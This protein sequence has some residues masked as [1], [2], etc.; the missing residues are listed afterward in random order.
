MGSYFRGVLIFPRSLRSLVQSVILGLFLDNPLAL[1]F[2]GVHKEIK[3]HGQVIN[4]RYIFPAGGIFL[5]KVLFNELA[6]LDFMCGDLPFIL[7]SFGFKHLNS[8]LNIS[9]WIVAQ[10]GERQ[11][12]RLKQYFTSNEFGLDGICYLGYLLDS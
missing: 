12:N 2:R 10:Q 4:E 11:L 6:G 1:F 8:I 5:I 9:G 3:G 7:I